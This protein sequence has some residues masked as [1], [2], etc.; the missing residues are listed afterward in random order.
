MIHFSKFKIL[1]LELFLIELFARVYHS[2]RQLH[3]PPCFQY[4]YCKHTIATTTTSWVDAAK[5]GV[6]QH[7][8]YKDNNRCYV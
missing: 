4:A 3:Y 1:F 8:N 2:I 6:D 5:M 7:F